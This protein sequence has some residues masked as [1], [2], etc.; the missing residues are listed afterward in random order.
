MQRGGLALDKNRIKGLL[1]TAL[2]AAL[3][4]VGAWIRIPVGYS[5]VTLQFFFCC[6]AG[7][8]LGPYKGAA[9]QLIY[10]LLGLVGLPVFTEGGGLTYVARPGFGFLLGLIPAAFLMGLLTKKRPCPLFRRILAALSGLAALYLLGLP[11]FCFA[12]KGGFSPEIAASCLV[13][14]PFDFLKL[15]FALLLSRK[16][17]GRIG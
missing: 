10:V 2:F 1:L 8:L 14:L 13:F 9:S 4:A 12:I 5:S 15:L 3:T 17:E 16:L 7:F 11:W 6:M